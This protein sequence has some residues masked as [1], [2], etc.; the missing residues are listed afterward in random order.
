MKIFRLIR[1]VLYVVVCHLAEIYVFVYVSDCFPCLSPVAGRLF[2]GSCQD[3][4]L[5]VKD[6]VWVAYA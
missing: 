1:P 2:C 3:F 5:R 6:T 4:V